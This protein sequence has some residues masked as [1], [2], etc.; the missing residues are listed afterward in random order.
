VAIVK[1]PKLQTHLIKPVLVGCLLLSSL[2]AC[3]LP[4]ATSSVPSPFASSPTT[5]SPTPD[6]VITLTSTPLHPDFWQ[7]L[8]VIP[9]SI[10]NRVR[11]IYRL[12][13]TLGNSPYVF[14]RIGDCASAAPAFLVGF[15][16]TYNLGEYK[17]LQPAID[18][19]QTSFDRPSLA[20]KGGLNTSELL[21]SLWNNEACNRDEILLDC[22]Y[23]I[24]RPSFAFISVGTNEA[25][26][27]HRDPESFERNLRIIL[28]DTI[29]KGII[30]ILDTKADN[31]EGDNSINTTIARL[32]IEYELP[33]WNFWLAVQALPNQGMSDSVRLNSISYTNYTDFSNPKS[34]DYGMQMRNLTALRMLDFL[35][36]KL[37][38]TS[39][40]FIEEILT[41][42]P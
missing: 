29:S 9:D 18:Y 8:P 11:E 28:D 15:D 33:F 34:L 36:K 26:T 30:P 31:I 38:S 39:P 37:S 3:N 35:R 14:S 22:Q 42:T 21:T 4:S 27:V 6:L 24:D 32:A 2:T 12:G 5:S 40:G 7:K 16:H 23:R 1:S 41:P 20:A 19:F 17:Y 13:Q 10:S 25:Y